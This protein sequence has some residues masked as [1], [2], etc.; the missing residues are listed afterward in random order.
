MGGLAA[1]GGGLSGGGYLNILMVSKYLITFVLVS[2][3]LNILHLKRTNL[4][5]ISR[6]SLSEKD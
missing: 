6:P 4:L 5:D 1:W 3:Y 2:L